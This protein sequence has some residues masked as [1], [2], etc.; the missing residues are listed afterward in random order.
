M[1][2]REPETFCAQLVELF[3]NAADQSTNRGIRINQGCSNNSQSA[4]SGTAHSTL[5]IHQEKRGAQCFGDNNRFALALVQPVL[6][7]QR[8]NSRRVW[9]FGN[10]DPLTEGLPDRR[11]NRITGAALNDFT[12]NRGR[13]S[14][15]AVNLMEEIE[16]RQ[17]SQV[18]QWAAIG[19]NRAHCPIFEA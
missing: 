11:L 4:L 9:R 6:T 10:R 13:N 16:V 14:E 1:P 3:S 8:L 19:Y 18:V 2:I 5:L 7:A 12:V 17:Q 15:R